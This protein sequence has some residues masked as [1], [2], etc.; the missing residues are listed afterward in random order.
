MTES[1]DEKKQQRAERARQNGSKSRGPSTAGAARSKLNGLN[2]GLR[3]RTY[4]L[5]DEED[6]DAAAQAEWK[7]R[8]GARSPAAVYHTRQCA[9]ASVTADRCERFVKARIADQKRKAVRNFRRRG[10]RR[11][12][13]ILARI[14]K[15]RLECI[16][17]LASFS[18][19]CLH[20]AE[21][22]ASSIRRVSS[23]GYLL[24][25]EIDWAVRAHGIGPVLESL[26]TDVTAYRLY[27]LN[28]GLTPGVTAAELDARLD[29]AGR[30]L[31]LRALPR[32]ALMPADP[33]VCGEQLRALIQKKCD[34]YQAKADRLRKECDEPELVRL[35][36]E[37]EFLSDADARRWQRCHAEQRLTFLRSEAALYKALDRDGEADDDRNDDPGPAGGGASGESQ[38]REE[39]AVAAEC[40]VQA[41]D[42]RPQGEAVALGPDPQAAVPTGTTGAGLVDGPDSAFG[43]VGGDS[44]GRRGGPHPQPEGGEGFLP[45]EPRIAL[46][47]PPQMMSQREDPAEAQGAGQ[48]VPSG[49]PDGAGHGHDRAPPPAPPLAGSGGGLYSPC[50][51]RRA[52]GGW[53]PR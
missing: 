7:A 53:V 31:A 25:G 27:I 22:L 11:V 3:A 5:A 18:D 13:D 19:G 21:I 1:S 34:A 49:A 8:Y 41:D 14:A 40:A 30:P 9:R 33:K 32:E 36:Q 6:A 2:W 4:P 28:L 35:L 46:E 24:P 10:P 15:G 45:S 29:P 20:L 50:R 44:A 43:P 12:K 17:D 23:Q 26:A 38:D 37:A 51:P 42:P 48:G 16:N 52:R 47:A 39:E